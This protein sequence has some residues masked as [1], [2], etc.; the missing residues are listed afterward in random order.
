[1]EENGAIGNWSDLVGNTR[2]HAG[3]C[4]RLPLTM[5][6]TRPRGSGVAYRSAK[7]FVSEPIDR[8][9]FWVAI[10]CKVIRHGYVV[11]TPHRLA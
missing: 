5:A 11:L 4:H 9:I 3:D 10:S 2:I 8:Y 6:G 7:R 1:M